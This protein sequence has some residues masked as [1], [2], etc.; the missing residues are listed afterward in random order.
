[1]HPIRAAWENPV[2]DISAMHDHRAD[3]LTV[4]RLRRGRA[5]MADQ[6][7]DLLDRDVGIRKQRDETVP[8]LARSPLVRIQP[9]RRN[10]RAEG[11]PDV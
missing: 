2:H 9:R 11:T 7:G 1:M 5:A 4:D 6:A 8:Q 10:Y 3:L